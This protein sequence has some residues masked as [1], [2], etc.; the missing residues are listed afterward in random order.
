VNDLFDLCRAANV[1]LGPLAF[2][3]LSYRALIG[4][5]DKKIIYWPL[6]LIFIGYVFVTALGPPTSIHVGN[7]ATYLSLLLTVL[8]ASLIFVCIWMPGPLKRGP[9]GVE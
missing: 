5:A 6:F 9:I 8:H 2:V 7:T 1:L 4:R 3:C